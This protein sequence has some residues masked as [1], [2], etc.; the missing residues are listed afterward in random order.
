MDTYT[1]TLA[2]TEPLLGTVPR[3]PEVYKQGPGTAQL[4]LA[5]HRRGTAAQS[6]ATA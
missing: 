5:R 2:F 3:D 6:T 4:R 1:V